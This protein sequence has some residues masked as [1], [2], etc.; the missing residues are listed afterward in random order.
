M[1]LTT[2]AWTLCKSCPDP[3]PHRALRP[4]MPLLTA[5]NLALSFGPTVLLDDADLNI[6]RGEKVGLVGI[7]GCGKSTLMRVLAGSER[8][9]S[10]DL[11]WRSGA[12]IAWLPQV[13]TLDETLSL[14]QVAMAGAQS[15][16]SSLEPFERELRAERTLGRLGVRD[17][18]LLVGHASGGARRRAALAAVLMEEPDILLLDEPT[19]HL[20]MAAV[21]WLEQHLQQLGCAIILTTHDRYFLDAVVDRIVEIRKHR[22]WSWPGT[23]SDWVAGRAEQEALEERTERNRKRL[24]QV[25]L[26]WLGRSPQARTTKQKARIQRVDELRDADEKVESRIQLQVRQG[27]RLGKTILNVRD[28]TVGFPNMPPLVKDLELSMI[29]GSRIGVVGPNGVGKTTLLR[30][31]AGEHAP[32]SGKLEV[33]HNTHILYIDQ[34]RSGLDDNATVRAS[35]TEAGGDWVQVGDERVHVVS[36]LERFLFASHDMQQRVSTLSGGQRFRLLLAQRLQQPMNLLLLDEPT[37]DLDF[38]T[39]GVLEEALREY[40]GC[41]LVVS[42]DRCFLDRVCTAMLHLPG[43]GA[44]E[45]HAGGFSEW[46]ARMGH[47]DRAQAQAARQAETAAAPSAAASVRPVAP[48]KPT[49]PELKFLDRIDAAIE[50]AEGAQAATE[51]M[52]TDPAVMADRT[53]L[54][55][56]MADLAAATADCERLYAEWAR[57]EAKN[58]AWQ[59]WRDDQAARR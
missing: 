31:F 2:A 49:M 32:L 28:L 30:T 34:E 50:V 52:L 56:A 21:H 20:D 8:A 48:A 14:R 39:L 27:G 11:A 42:H 7:N 36:W 35:A 16:V 4:Y 33:G 57:I 25:E 46:E 37:N 58:E 23:F 41:L 26:Q 19:N 13:P 22:L 40:A 12:R 44:W 5:Q 6:A 17:P 51:G 47:R 55:A 1:W 29:R 53:K 24:L 3:L 10:G 9:D 45:L 54:A 15:S 18:D 59:T 43:D 38:E